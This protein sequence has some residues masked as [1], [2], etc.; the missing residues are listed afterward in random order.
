MMSVMDHGNDQAAPGELELVRE[1]VN[2]R[3]VEDGSD[4]LAIGAEAG[5]WMAEHGLPGGD[6]PLTGADLERLVAV[7]EALRALLLANNSGGRPPAGALE[8]LNEQ[9]AE[10]AIGLRFEAEGAALITRC[11][12]V[13]STIARLL[14]RVHE[15]MRD[16]TWRRL[17]ACPADDCLWAFYDHS[18]NRSG[19][20][21]RMEECGNRSK[22]RA[23]RARRRRAADR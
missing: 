16:G 23:Y 20:W 8:T 11:D 19:T 22:A 17:K 1:F 18:R 2:T 21:C 3:D 5:A 15:A 13:D 14:S 9:S 7:R 4:R 6:E 12:G 10:A